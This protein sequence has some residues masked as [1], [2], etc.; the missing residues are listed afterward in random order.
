MLKI[1]NKK[2]ECSNTGTEEQKDIRLMENKYQNRHQSY[3]VS[4]YI[5]DKKNFK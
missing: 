4:N 5:K 2:K 1:F 3:L